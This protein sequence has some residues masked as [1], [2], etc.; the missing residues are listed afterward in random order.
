[1]PEKHQL[2]FDYTKKRNDS[3]YY[4]EKI[5]NIKIDSVNHTKPPAS[6][7]SRFVDYQVQVR[8]EL[9]FQKSHEEQLL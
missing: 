4:I 2:Y 6:A 1:M 5:L 9:P 3:K 8:I 7:D